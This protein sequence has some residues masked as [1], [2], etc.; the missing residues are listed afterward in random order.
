M[1]KIIPVKRTA[2]DG[3]LWWYVYDTEARKLSTLLCFGK[4]RTKKD[5]QCAIDA[6][7]NKPVDRR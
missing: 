7:Y 1:K 2:I 3:K 6:Y 5:C 4:Y